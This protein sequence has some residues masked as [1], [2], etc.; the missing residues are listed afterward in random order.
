MPKVAP[1]GAG[2]G[3]GAAA[4]LE[5]EALAFEQQLCLGIVSE[6]VDGH[7]HT[8]VNWDACVDGG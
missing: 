5:A 4:A 2:A 7:P 3:N 1:G 8:H 6:V